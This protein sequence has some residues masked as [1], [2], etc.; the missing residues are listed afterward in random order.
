MCGR[1]SL[2]TP[3]EAMRQL[4][5][6]TGPPPNFPPRYN[7]APSQDAPVVR[8]TQDGGRELALLRWGLVPSWSQGPDAKFSMINARAETVAAKPAYRGAF[9]SRRC[10]VPADGFFEWHAEKPGKQP[11]FIGLKNGGLFA[12]AGLWELWEKST[13]AIQSFTIIVTQANA[14]LSQIH[15]RMPVILDPADYGAW[16]DP[17][18]DTDGAQALLRPIAPD[19]MAF[20]KVSTRVNSQQNDDPECL[21]PLEA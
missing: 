9:K 11:Y 19:K 18:T 13:P 12:F 15:D 21:A 3:A 1:Y 16:L 10:L 14:H 4:F 5:R 7:I 8:A 6:L 20:R 17:A 2:T